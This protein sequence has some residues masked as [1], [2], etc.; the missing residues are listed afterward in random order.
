MFIDLLEQGAAESGGRLCVGLD[1]HAELVPARFGRSAAGVGDFL[2]W[3]IEETLPHA[4][5]FKPNAAFFEAHG[6][7]G[8][9]LLREIAAILHEK[10]RAVILDA[11]RGDIASSAAAYA[12]AAVDVLGVDAITIVPYMGADAVRPFLDRGAFVFLLAL[13]TNPSAE[14]VACHGE[15]PIC[16]RVAAMAE[17]LSR[18]YSRQVGLVVGATRP[19]W[20]AGI[21]A[22]APDLPWL[23]PGVG[24]QGADVEAFL[25][26]ADGHE[27]MIV[28]ASR[29]ILGSPDP[30]QA[31]S[32]LKERIT[33][34]RV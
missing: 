32:A 30:R 26:A 31:A 10:R 6:A 3:V 15:P 33:W 28:S 16:V 4:S 21:H 13:P 9:D 23:V 24:A 22:Q 12:V 34:S 25:D 20:V 27:P 29:S 11:K 19:A 1:P 17:R 7:A 2:R 5:V 8:F 14:E 18:E